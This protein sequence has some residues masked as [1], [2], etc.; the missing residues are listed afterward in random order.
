MLTQVTLEH[1]FVIYP[2]VYYMY[3]AL[4]VTQMKQN[5]YKSHTLN[6]TLGFIH[7]FFYIYGTSKIYVNKVS[8]VSLRSAMASNVSKSQNFNM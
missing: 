2:N 6:I 3:G 1:H 8:K 7:M 4:S 5:N